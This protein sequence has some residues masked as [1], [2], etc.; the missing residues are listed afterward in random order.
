LLAAGAVRRI[1]V[2][3]GTSDGE[4]TAVSDGPLHVGDTVLFELTPDGRKA[5]GITH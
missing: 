5:Y 4:L 1:A 3:A 2:Q